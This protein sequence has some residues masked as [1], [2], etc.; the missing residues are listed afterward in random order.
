MELR[1]LRR[2]AAL[3][4]A[5]LCT[6]LTPAHAATLAA[7]DFDAPDGSF[8]TD[9]DTLAP[10]VAVGAWQDLD[11]TLTSFNGTAG[12]ALGARSFD[13]GNSL[14]VSL[15]SL[16]A[17]LRLDE[18]RF[19]QQ[20]SGTGPTTWTARINGVV[21]GSAAT[22]GTLTGIV[23]PLALTATLFEISLEGSGASSG[24]GTWRIDNVM[25]SGASPVPVPATLPLL[26][27]ALVALRARRRG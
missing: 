13:N 14:T 12:R 2:I 21:V 18:L 23:I 11:G 9:V 6:A 4:L 3:C 7:W 16:G 5:T 20:A 19:E 8:S 24:Q 10:G 22:A 15:Q 26:A 25:L 17:A 27:S 1:P